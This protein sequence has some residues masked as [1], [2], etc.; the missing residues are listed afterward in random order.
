MLYKKLILRNAKALLITASQGRTSVC[1]L[2]FHTCYLGLEKVAITKAVVSK[3]LF[4]S[5]LAN[6]LK[7]PQGI[8][9]D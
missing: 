2:P 6:P 8:G 4:P 7:P 5:P 3:E 9:K 1:S